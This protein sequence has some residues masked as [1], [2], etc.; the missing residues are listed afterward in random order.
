MKLLLD[1]GNTRLKW[2]TAT[3]T[4]GAVS[5]AVHAGNPIA[6]FRAQRW[7][8]VQEVWLACVPS[9]RDE[10]CWREAVRAACGREPQIVIATAQWQGLR[11][12]YA[13]P[14][15]L[16]VDRW[17]AMVALWAEQRSAFCVAAAGT[18][19][20][21]DRVAA[22][23]RHLGGLIAPGLGASQRNLL[24]VTVTE[25][26]AQDAYH[27]GLGQ[28]SEEAIRQ[29]SYFAARGVIEHALRAP[30]ADPAERR[31]LTGGDAPALLAQLPAPWTLKPQLVLEGLLALS[32]TSA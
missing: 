12:A 2:A 23:G 7:P 32:R 25:A 9:L 3:D 16:G 15:K 1:V 28:H 30:G 10:P 24:K 17:L 11:N 26:P 8:A 6:W 19:L 29:G 20:T 14:H 22:D 21:F 4:L 31:I 18:A 13:E 27:Q 5:A